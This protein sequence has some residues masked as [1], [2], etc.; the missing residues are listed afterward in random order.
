M[1]DS[2]RGI[3]K[4]ASGIDGLDAITSSGLP[5][6]RPTLIAGGAG[7]GKTLF[8]L[9]FLIEG[10]VRYQE[11]GVFVTFEESPDELS[12]NIVSLGHDLGRLTKA[13]QIKI[14]HVKFEPGELA[15]VGEYNLDGLF[16]RLGHAIDSLKAKRVVVDTIEVLLGGLLNTSIVRTELRRLFSW[17]KS[18]GVTS[19]ITAER[20]DGGLTR[21]GLEEY[22]SD[23]VIMLDQRVQSEIATRRLR[24]VKYRGSAH[25]TNEYPFI[26]DEEGISVFPVTSLRL[27][28]TASSER[29]PTGVEL[30][31]SMLGGGG[32]YRG[33]SVLI[34]GTA[35]TGK[36]SFC[37][38]IAAAA[39]QRAEP[40]IYFSFEESAE[41]MVRNMRS[42]GM[43][44]GGYCASDRL[45]F[46]AARPSL[47]GLDAHLAVM[48]R[49]IA[50]RSPALVIVDPISA[51]LNIGTESQVHGLHLRIVDMLKARG[52]TALFASLGWT[53]GAAGQV[54]SL[55][56]SLIDTWIVL[57][58]HLEGDESNRTL[59]IRKSRGM[60]HS[61]QLREFVLTDSGIQLPEP[62]LGPTM[63]PAWRRIQEPRRSSHSSPPSRRGQ[64]VDWA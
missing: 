57:A 23:C 36:S 6:G 24:V 12:E 25:G 41:Q 59:F 51:L 34:S 19:I 1:A 20:G 46:H 13:G 10:A 43:D 50:R 39:C 56:S 26:I 55:V 3:R 60:A 49:E 38:T 47:Q 30:F 35:G 42:L 17:L 16:I 28:H 48:E 37:A 31:D 21:S 62:Y 4:S 15:E 33:S 52:I 54:D 27:T 29:M 61:N 9:T 22:V 2:R 53:E 63:A 5:T 14:E 64:G 45:Y 40:C 58:D 44:L 32:F 7:C 18:K 11:P 8:A